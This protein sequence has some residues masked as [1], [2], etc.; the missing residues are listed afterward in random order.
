MDGAPRQVGSEGQCHRNVETTSLIL[1]SRYA[2]VLQAEGVA[3]YSPALRQVLSPQRLEPEGCK[4]TLQPKQKI[5]F[6]QYG[7]KGLAIHAWNTSRWPSKFKGVQN[8]PRS[9]I[10][11]W[12]PTSQDRSLIPFGPQQQH[13]SIVIYSNFFCEAILDHQFERLQSKADTSLQMRAA[14]R[15]A[16]LLNKMQK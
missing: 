10:V 15:G 3:E 9:K 16:T 12:R 14:G 8:G 5:I 11:V 4:N 1:S 13:T 7:R 6:L 2:R